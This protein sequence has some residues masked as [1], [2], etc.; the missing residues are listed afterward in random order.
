MRS[1]WVGETP[2]SPDAE[3]PPSNSNQRNHPVL[4]ESLT[5]I[6]GGNWGAEGEVVGHVEDFFD[7]PKIFIIGT[8]F[9]I[10]SGSIDSY[11]ILM[12]RNYTAH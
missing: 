11:V 4:R 9:C 2:M 5:E 3:A 10:F 6:G 7:L 12:G 1:E 8:L